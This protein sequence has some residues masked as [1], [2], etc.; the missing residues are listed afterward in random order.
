MGRGGGA[1]ADILSGGKGSDIFMLGDAGSGRDIVT[2][3]GTGRDKIRI[4]TENADE[5]T[6]KALKAAAQIRWTQ[7]R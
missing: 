6:I 2:D 7:K 3:F 4:D 1:G 5:A